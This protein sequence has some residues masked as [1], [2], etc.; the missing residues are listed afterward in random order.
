M[1]Y[2]MLIENYYEDFTK[3]SDLKEG[4]LV[5]YKNIKGVVTFICDHSLS[6]LVKAFAGEPARDVKVVVYY[7]EWHLVTPLQTHEIRSNLRQT[8]EERLCETECYVS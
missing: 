6:I 1:L 8:Q 4:T 2:M 5:E 3:M 7:D